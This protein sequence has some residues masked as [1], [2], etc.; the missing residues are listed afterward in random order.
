MLKDADLIEQFAESLQSRR[1]GCAL[2]KKISNWLLRLTSG[3][4]T[5]PP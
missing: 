1:S 4:K 3:K 5:L 2:S